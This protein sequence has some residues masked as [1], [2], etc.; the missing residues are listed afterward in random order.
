M[1]QRSLDW[2]RALRRNPPDPAMD[3]PELTVA[4]IDERDGYSAYMWSKSWITQ[5]GAT[6]P[7]PWLGYAASSVI[8]GQ[9]KGAV[10]SL[11]L[12]LRVWI[13]ALPDRAILVFARGTIIWRRMSD[14]KTALS[15]LQAA[16]DNAPAWLMPTARDAIE[17]CS[18]AA[19]SSK[20]RKRSV[21]PPP[22][23]VGSDTRDTVEPRA[24]HFTI[25][26]RPRLWDAFLRSLD[27]D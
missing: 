27:T 7:D 17:A 1:S 4:A 22:V 12:G 5:G 16:A 21:E 8:Q 19:S 2:M 11:D 25:G 26:E 18:S 6:A 3:F 15:D 14:P 20:K 13:E 23:H 9:P 24:A 10:N